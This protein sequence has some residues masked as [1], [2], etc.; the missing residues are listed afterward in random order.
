MKAQSHNE[1][2]FL[3]QGHR[4]Q[5][6]AL[7]SGLYV[8]S[9]PIGNLGDIT[10]RALQVLAAADLVLCEDTR[11]T[12]RLIQHYS[13]ET[14]LRPY[15]EHNAPKVRPAVLK[16]LQSG[17]AIAL[18]SDAGTPLVSDP[19]YRLVREAMALGITVTAVPGASAPLAALAAAGLPSDRVLFA[20]FLPDRQ[21][22]RRRV[23]EELRDAAATLVFF[24]AARKLVPVLADLEDVLGDREA[25]VARELTK[26]HEEF[27]RGGV[28]D[29]RRTV[30]ARGA[31]KGEVTL[32][33]AGARSGDAAAVDDEALDAEIVDA[34]RGASVRD[35]AAQ[36][37]QAHGLP[38]RRVYQRAL[39][40]S[41]AGPGES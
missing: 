37:A 20:G 1:K 40:L 7:D 29:L 11:V 14:P 31:L 5:A 33:V 19:G 41:R 9:T 13:I 32:L 3:L 30:A 24:V 28:S 36:V 26:L 21:A 4:F 35:V 25:V 10:V 27:L 2:E 8:T 16:R 38:R 18:V 6:P 23:V 15:H 12:R 34:L 22:Q 39:E 17:A